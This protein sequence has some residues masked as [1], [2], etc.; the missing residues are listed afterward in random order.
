MIVPYLL[1]LVVE[2]PLAHRFLLFFVTY[3]HLAVI[4][5]W[6]ELINACNEIPRPAFAAPALLLSVIAGAAIVGGNVWLALLEFD[7]RTLSPL[8]RQIEDKRRATPDGISVPELYTSLLE[9]LDESAVVLSTAR[10]GWPV[11]TFRGRVVSLY[12]ENPLLEDQAQRY[13]DTA[14]FFYRPVPDL[15]RVEIIQRYDVYHVLVDDADAGLHQSVLEWLRSFGNVVSQVGSYRL[16]ALPPALHDI[17]LPEPEPETEPQSE[18]QPAP[19]RSPAPASQARPEPPVA[20]PASEAAQ[21]DP[22]EEP[23]A[24]GPPADESRSFGAPIAPP[25]LDPTRHGAEEIPGELRGVSCGA[26]LR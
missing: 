24:S 4:W 20:E 14:D 18:S 2:I 23:S 6:L 7:G 8:T 13:A 11:P 17:R 5:A 9:P 26:G 19:E 1:N 15:R 16:Y 12:H 10:T 22:E 25:V 21:P 3:L